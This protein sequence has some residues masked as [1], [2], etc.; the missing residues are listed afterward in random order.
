MLQ[1][2]LIQN[3]QIQVTCYCQFGVQVVLTENIYV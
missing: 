2:T 3:V 1:V